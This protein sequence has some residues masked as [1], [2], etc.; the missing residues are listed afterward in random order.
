VPEVPKT[1]W[2]QFRSTAGKYTIGEV[3][4]ADMGYAI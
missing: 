4:D 1:I 2:T 3:F